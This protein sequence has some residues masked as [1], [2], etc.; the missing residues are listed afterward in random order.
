MTRVTRRC[1]RHPT[2]VIGE[3]SARAEGKARAGDAYN[4]D[5]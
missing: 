2:L 4:P 3:Q 5:R 1:S